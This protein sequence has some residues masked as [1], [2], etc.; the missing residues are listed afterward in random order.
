MRQKATESFS[1]W[2]C[3]ECDEETG[4]IFPKSLGT[5]KDAML[6]HAKTGHKVSGRVVYDYLYS[7]KEVL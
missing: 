6:H 3:G 1:C 4:I 7:H 2:E 5:R